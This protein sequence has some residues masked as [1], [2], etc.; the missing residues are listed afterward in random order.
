MPGILRIVLQSLSFNKKPV[1][2]QV[3]IILLLSAVI[4]GSLLTG[5]SVKMSLKKS[6]SEHLGNADILISTGI[7]YFDPEL[8]NRIRDSAHLSCSGIIEING[9][10][11][12][13]N[14]QKV[15]LN[16]HIYGV[17][18]DFFVFQENNSIALNSG[19]VAINKRLAEN[20]NIKRGDDIIIRFKEISSIP[21]DA[22]FA[23]AEKSGRSIVMKV[24]IILEPSQGGN[25][26]LSITQITPLNVFVNLSDLESD[27]N[28]FKI[29]RLL[30]KKSTDY[31]IREVSE[32]LKHNLK[33]ADIGL[34]IRSLK[35]TGEGELY[36]D[37]IFIDEA[38]IKKIQEILPSSSPV[39]TYLGNRFELNNRSTPYSFVSAIPS[40]LYPEIAAGNDMIINEWMAND[41]AANEGDTLMMYWYAPDSLNK[42]IEKKSHFVVNRIVKMTGIWSDSLLMPVFPGISG[43]ESCSDWDA[44]VP[45]KMNQIRAKDEEYWK[46]YRGTPKAFI[47]YEKG[48]ELWGNNFGPATSIRYPAGI[49][50]QFIET[51]LAGSLDPQAMGFT[52]ND[53]S[54]ESLR[55]AD[56]GIDF[57][58]LFLSL[59]F[60]LIIASLVLLS[61]A[62]SSYFDSESR[63]LNT[64]YALGFKNRWV[65][66]FLLLKTGIIAFAGC[67]TGALTGYIFNIFITRALNTVWIG[68]VQ[69]NTL[70]VHFDA[71]SAFTGFTLTFLILMSFMWIKVRRY[72]KGLKQRAKA[73]DKIPSLG[74]NHILLFTSI[75]ISAFFFILYETGK[76]HQPVYPFISG[77]VL[78]FSFVLFWR[79]LIIGRYLSG[80]TTV[81]KSKRLSLQYYAFSSGSAITPI[82]FIAAG[83]FTVFITSTNR[84]S[85][86]AK[87]IKRSGGTGGYILWCENAIS[88]QEDMNTESGK[89]ILGLDIDSLSQ[90]SYI[91]MKKFSGNDASCLNLNHIT[92]PPIL[93][94]DPA[95][96]ILKKSFSFSGMLAHK[97]V[98]NPW[99][100]LNYTSQNNTIYGIAD[101]TVLEWGLKIKTGDTLVVRAENGYPLNIVIAAGLQTSV[102]Q[103]NMLIG[104]RNF[105][106]Y[107]PSVAGSSVFLVDGNRTLADFYKA[108]LNERLENHGISIEKTTDRLASFYQVTNTYLSVFSLLGAMGM[109]IG[110]AGL[111]FVLLRNYSQ[112]KSSFALML[113][114]GFPLKKIR[115]L[116][117]SE[118][119]LILLSGVITGTIP[120]LLATLPSLT[121]NNNLPWMFIIIMTI[122]IFLTGAFSAFLALRSIEFNA[123]VTD[124]KKE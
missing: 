104:K 42:L 47:S 48:R 108:A 111:G 39:I 37:R 88:V 75:L 90:V 20:L 33:P 85:F 59:G 101:Q 3:L 57:G 45:I 2:Y 105:V 38:I 30:I 112:R 16:T 13:M 91:Q 77:S 62:T 14:S 10:C 95:D 69:T 106:K 40:A 87:E 28:V 109:V 24:A 46:R 34:K 66:T 4:T 110:V 15:V 31:T 80:S 97:G 61:F 32:A 122:S 58:S 72:L 113:A 98:T 36:S 114:I 35:K 11:Q 19:E 123:L 100:Y 83:I 96:F 56:E 26:S 118:Q 22:P 65:S 55:A 9:Y 81:I 71:L 103:G 18:N 60:F 102:F 21:A 82:L 67:A 99:D 73:I 12:E 63:Y 41:L 44:G 23:S 92:A 89:K 52:I 120:A 5:K 17:G 43:K 7:R 27:L 86:N 117:L 25:F 121:N 78:L 8:V 84:M 70:Q 116:I 93:G 64:L 6:A 76:D 119:I 79:Q 54:S 74:L 51:S 115:G 94:I 50:G 29:N 68:A 107:F 1:L 53:L 49:T 124:L